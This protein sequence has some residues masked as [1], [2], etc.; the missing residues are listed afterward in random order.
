MTPSVCPTLSGAVRE[1]EGGDDRRHHGDG[2]GAGEVADEHEAPVAQHAVERHARPLVDQGERTQ[3]ENAGQQV[4]AEQVEHAEA[5]RE[6][7]RA[8]ERLAGRA[9]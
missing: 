5:D 1:A 8:D 3:D 7:D 2:E 4:E 9:R 6:Q